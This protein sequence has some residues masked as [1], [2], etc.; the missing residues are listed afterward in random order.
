MLTD[1]KQ[2]ELDLA[3]E[4]FFTNIFGGTTL[5]AKTQ[6]LLN[7]LDIDIN[8]QIQNFENFVKPLMSDNGMVDVNL[9]RAV[10]SSKYPALYN[11]LPANNFRLVDVVDGLS[12]TL[13]LLMKGVIK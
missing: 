3:E 9:A 10:I 8:T 11:L 12:K 2:N 4:K 1:I 13:K 6:W 5:D 7:F